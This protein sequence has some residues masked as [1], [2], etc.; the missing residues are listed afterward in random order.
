MEA[1]KSIFEDLSNP[2]LLEKCLHGKTQNVNE[3]FNNF[4]WKNI[5]KNTFV[6]IETLKTGVYDAV[7]AFND[8]N[9]SRC[10]VLRALSIEP[11]AFCISALKADDKRRLLAADK[12]FLQASKTERQKRSRERTA[13]EEEYEE[14]EGG[15]SY[16]TGEF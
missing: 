2:A 8:G 7:S 15:P 11:G 3:S 6:G 1:I 13:L 16:G 12:N 10:K 14:A 9:I 5:P 4:V